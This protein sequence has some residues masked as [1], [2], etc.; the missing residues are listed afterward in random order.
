[1]MPGLMRIHPPAVKI[2]YNIYSPTSDLGVS[3][4]LALKP[5]ESVICL[6]DYGW[7][8]DATS[9]C[10][11]YEFI[12]FFFGGGVSQMSQYSKDAN[13]SNSEPTTVLLSAGWKHFFHDPISFSPQFLF[14]HSCL[15]SSFVT[16]VFIKTLVCFIYLHV[17]YN[18]ILIQSCLSTSKFSLCQINKVHSI[19]SVGLQLTIIFII[20]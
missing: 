20:D 13:H 15:S 19:F 1:M 5:S 3:L 12:W 6:S 14:Q 7:G 10:F 2:I 8:H 17:V 4:R 16:I 9:A 11:H 18:T